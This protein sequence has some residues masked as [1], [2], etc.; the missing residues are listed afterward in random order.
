MT[1]SVPF[2]PSRLCPNAASGQLEPTAVPRRQGVK[3]TRPAMARGGRD[4]PP[5]EATPPEPKQQFH[6]PRHNL[7]DPQPE[8]PGRHRQAHRHPPGPHISKTSIV[9]GRQV[10]GVV[11]KARRVTLRCLGLK[12][13]G[14]LA[15]V[16]ETEQETDQRGS[17][18]TRK[19]QQATESLVQPAMPCQ[20]PPRR[21][22]RGSEI[23]TDATSAR[24]RD[25]EVGPFPRREECPCCARP[26]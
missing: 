13:P 14:E 6:H 5:P 18:L 19:P 12:L 2:L 9:M 23:P 20:F 15:D 1:C 22:H 8:R 24:G 4:H 17:V 26:R 25:C 21:P 3:N 7:G 11:A 16:M 10:G